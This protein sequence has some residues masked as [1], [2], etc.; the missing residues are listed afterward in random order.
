MVGLSDGMI[1][2][3]FGC[4]IRHNDKGGLNMYGLNRY[5]LEIL[6]TFRETCMYPSL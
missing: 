3:I 6:Q 4:S 5:L 2:S 1:G